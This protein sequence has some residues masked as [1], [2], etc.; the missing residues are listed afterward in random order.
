MLLFPVVR[1]HGRCYAVLALFSSILLLG[2]L[3]LES[4]MIDSRR[5]D[6]DAMLAALNSLKQN[7]AWPE[8]IGM[9]GDAGMLIND[10]CFHRW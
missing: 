3:L 6:F 10:C 8:I 5:V 2:F 1:G 9:I 7:A 4:Q